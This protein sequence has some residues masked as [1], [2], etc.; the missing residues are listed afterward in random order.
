M[1]NIGGMIP[2]PSKVNEEMLAIKG[3]VTLSWREVSALGKHGAYG[4]NW[5]HSPDRRIFNFSSKLL[6]SFKS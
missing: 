3:H 1:N 4:W 5:F 2:L 6:Q